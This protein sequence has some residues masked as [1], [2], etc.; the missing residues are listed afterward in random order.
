MTSNPLLPAP[1]ILRRLAS[2]LYD[3]LLLTAVLFIAV[4]AFSSLTAYKGDGPLRPLFQLYIVA[5]TAAYFLFFWRNSGQTLAM[6]TWHIKL[7]SANGEKIGVGQCLIRIA[8]AAAGI[9][10]G[11][12]G[13]WWAIADR[14]KQFLHDR[15]AG[16][17]LLLLEKKPA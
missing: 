16:T 12:A 5:I 15:L 10:L 9:A 6:K 17:R 1:G 2:M 11:G 14:D 7:V 13:L 8:L 3:G 4:F